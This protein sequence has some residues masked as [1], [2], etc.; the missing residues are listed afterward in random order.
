M[1][2][3]F[4]RK[5]IFFIVWLVLEIHNFVFS[6]FLEHRFLL[7]H[8]NNIVKIEM[9]FGVCLMIQVS[10]LFNDQGL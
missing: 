8:T 4:N 2:F 1:G 5:L 6:F 7:L 9:G 3:I 10:D